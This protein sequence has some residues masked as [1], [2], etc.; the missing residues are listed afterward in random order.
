M[1]RLFY[2]LSKTNSK[3]IAKCSKKAKY[4]QSSFGLFVLFTGIVA[5]FSGTYALKMAFHSNSSRGVLYSLIGGLV[6]CLIIMAFD[7]EIVASKSKWAI[8]IRIPLALMIGIIVS[9]PL[10]LSILEGRIDEQ[11]SDELKEKNAPNLLKKENEIKY[12]KDREIEL[13]LQKKNINVTIDELKVKIYNEVSGKEGSKRGKGPIYWELKKQLTYD[14]NRLFNIENEISKFQIEKDSTLK[15]LER[16]YNKE[17]PYKSTDL[18]SRYIALQRLK[19]ND[20]PNNINKEE[21]AK[22]TLKMSWALSLLIIFIELFP[23]FMKLFKEETDYDDLQH[24]QYQINQGVIYTKTNH[25]LD[26]IEQSPDK[27]IQPNAIESIQNQ[28]EVMK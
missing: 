16:H 6:Y 19:H 1:N 9:L 25:H 15:E 13:E 24:A 20:D 26:K 2:F 3:L 18:L 8:I 28:M 12:L 17:I 11:L 23:A 14:S 10:E 7:R 21:E 27:F 5:F 22:A 4:T